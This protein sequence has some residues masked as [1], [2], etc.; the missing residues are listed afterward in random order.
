MA[1][2]T[3]Y[4][5]RNEGR[6]RKWRYEVECESEEEAVR[7][8]ADGWLEPIDDGEYGE[9]DLGNSGMVAVESEGPAAW[10]AAFEDLSKKI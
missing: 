7:L 3:V 10:H 6:C 5:V 9:G 2:Y 1:K 4:E 8:A